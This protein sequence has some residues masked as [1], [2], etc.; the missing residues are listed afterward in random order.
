MQ[1]AMS[2]RRARQPQGSGREDTSKSWAPIQSGL[3]GQVTSKSCLY[4]FSAYLLSPYQV[5]GTETHSEDMVMNRTGMVSSLMPI[6]LAELE[7]LG[8]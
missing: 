6:Y 4:L 2:I 8:C 3:N 7:A 1:R 5:P